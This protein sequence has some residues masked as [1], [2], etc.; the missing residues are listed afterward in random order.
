MIFVIK[1]RPE[2][3]DNNKLKPVNTDY[4]SLLMLELNDRVPCQVSLSSLTYNG[5]GHW[6]SVKY[7]AIM[8]L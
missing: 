4:T 1:E 8:V 5:H 2:P 3:K 7:M 6:V